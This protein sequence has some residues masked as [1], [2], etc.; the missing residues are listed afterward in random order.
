M[1]DRTKTMSS[2]SAMKD[3]CRCRC[4]EMYHEATS[5][6][7]PYMGPPRFDQL[8]RN[9]EE[10]ANIDRTYETSAAKSTG[11]VSRHQRCV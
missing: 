9:E 3:E 10:D 11:T 4:P 8:A 2:S 1:P 5:S 6:T 7:N